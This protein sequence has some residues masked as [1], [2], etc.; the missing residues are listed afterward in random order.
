MDLLWVLWSLVTA[1]MAIHMEA[2]GSHSMFT[3]EPITLRMCHDLPYNSTFM[4]NLLNH[5]DQQTAALAMEVSYQCCLCF[6]VCVYVCVCH[7]SEAVDKELWGVCPLLTWLGDSPVMLTCWFL[8]GLLPLSPASHS[9]R[10]DDC[11][12]VSL[13]LCLR[14]CGWSQTLLCSA[15]TSMTYVLKHKK[16][17]VIYKC[18]LSHH[19]LRL[20]CWEYI[21]QLLSVSLKQFCDVSSQSSIHFDG[22]ILKRL[23]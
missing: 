1:S 3:C 4:P 19:S 22:S 9:L 15:L 17:S 7:W 18:C 23:C 13:F 14:T 20:L 11:L 10:L 21:L 6:C 5:Y 16:H 12:S 2:G 8:S